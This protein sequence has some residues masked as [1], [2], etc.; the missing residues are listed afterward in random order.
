MPTWAQGDN[1]AF[2]DRTGRHIQE[3]H[4]AASKR[5]RPIGLLGNRSNKALTI[6]ELRK[7][8]QRIEK[9]HQDIFEDT[10]SQNGD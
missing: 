4:I 3:H 10:N 7:Q 6:N 2:L 9:Q 8:A 1:R 5:K